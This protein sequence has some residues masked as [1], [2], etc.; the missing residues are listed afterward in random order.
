MP[1][2]NKIPSDKIINATIASLQKNN[3][4]V[5]LVNNGGEAKAKVLEI[6]PNNAEV[7]NMSSTTLLTLGLDK[8][9]NE[10]GKYSSVRNKFSGM[11]KDTQGLEMQKMGA[12]PEWTIGSVHAVTQNGEV[13]VASQ[14]GSQLPAYA[15][16]S[17]HVIW[18]VGAQKITKDIKTATKRL[19][20]YVLPLESERAH[21]AYNVPGSAVNKLLIINKEVKPNRIT[22]I[23]VK[24]VLGF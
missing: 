12:A 23:L 11:N 14:S 15:F 24:E 3:I 8:Y 5:I 10:S 2:Y 1:T 21:K 22:M 6:L 17:Q 13:L 18:V 16:G 7:M 20:D 19:Y 4:M 9:I